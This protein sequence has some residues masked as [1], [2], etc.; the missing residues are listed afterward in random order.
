VGEL[1]LLHPT[2]GTG[3]VLQC[4]EQHTVIHFDQAGRL[5]FAPWCRRDPPESRESGRD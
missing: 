4:N 3:T 5:N 2:F 1:S